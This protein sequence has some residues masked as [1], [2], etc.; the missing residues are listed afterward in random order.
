MV[1]GTVG[2]IVAYAAIVG[3][4]VGSF[5]N[6]FVYRFP[7]RLRTLLTVRSYCPVCR[8]QIKGYDNVPLVSWFVLG[9]RCRACKTP[10]SIRYPLV[11]IG[12]GMLGAIVG[13]LIVHSMPDVLYVIGS[14]GFAGGSAMW[15][16]RFAQI[17]WGRQ[18]MTT[19]APKTR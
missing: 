1:R 9:G 11:E 14:A 15:V 2:L 17:A 4:C 16:A 3:L 19:R 5:M 18:S 6:A 7:D 12:C 10:I 8:T 13:A